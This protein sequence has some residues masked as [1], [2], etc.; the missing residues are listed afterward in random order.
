MTF[1][2]GRQ[3]ISELSWTCRICTRLI[4]TDFYIQCKNMLKIR[5]NLNQFIQSRE[6][7]EPPPLSIS[8]LCP[9]SVPVSQT[10]NHS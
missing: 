7:V 1:V 3:L 4:H 6:D 10:N 8:P 2:V 5:M 9:N